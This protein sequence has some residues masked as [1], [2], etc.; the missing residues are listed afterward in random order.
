VVA[1]GEELNATAA[2]MLLLVLARFPT[3]RGLPQ[4]RRIRT[5]EI[6]SRAGGSLDGVGTYHTPYTSTRLT[7]GEPDVLHARHRPAGGA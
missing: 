6:D 1:G 3:A 7:T 2:G 5:T 4:E